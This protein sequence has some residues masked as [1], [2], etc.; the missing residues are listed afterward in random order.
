M[1]DQPNYS[2]RQRS[3]VVSEPQCQRGASVPHGAAGPLGRMAWRPLLLLPLLSVAVSGNTAPR[4][5]M[6]IVSVPE[7]LP[8]GASAFWL[9]AVDADGDQLYY[10]MSGQDAFY[11]KVDS[12]TGEVLLVAS[13]DREEKAKLSVIITVTDQINTEVSGKLAIIVEDRNDNPPI[14]QNQPYIT[15]LSETWPIGSSI[16]RVLAT[17]ADSGSAGRVRYEIVSVTP[18]DAKNHQLF[19]ILQNGTVVLNGSLNY[20]SQSTYY[21]LRIN[22]TDGV[23]CVEN[24]TYLSSVAYLSVNVVDEPDLAPQFLNEPYV[25]SVPENCPLGTPVLTVS[26]IDRD[27]GVNYALNYSLLN[28]SVPF[29]IHLA[30]GT[31]TVRSALDRERLPSEEVLLEVLVQEEKLDIYGQ[32]AQASA[33]V[34][35]QVTDVNDN[36]PQFYECELPA[37]DFTASPQSSFRGSLE[38]HSST[39]VPVGGLHIVAHDPDKGSNGAFELQLQGP[40]AASFSVSPSRLTGTGAVQVLVKDPSTVDYERTH[41][42]TVE[43]I[44]NDTGNPG[45]CCSIAIVTIQLL[46][47]NDHSPR[48]GQSMYWLPVLENSPAGTVISSNITATDPDSADFGRITY[49]LLPETILDIFAV[50]ASSGEVLVRNGS[51]LDRETRSVYYATLQAVDG[52][53]MT[54]STYL[55]ITLQDANDNAPVVS[56]SYNVFVNEGQENISVQIQAFDNDEPGTSNSH[57]RFQLEPGA[58]SAN[59]TIDPATGVLRSLGALDRE[60]LGRALQG[61]VVVTVRVHDLGVPQLSSLVNVTI[62]VEDVNDNAPVFLNEPYV[63]SVREGQAG[64]FVG[65]VEAEDA[66]QTEVHHRISFQLGSSSSSFLLR[67]VRLGPGHYQGNLSL[68]PDVAL[69]YDRL[70]PAHF[71]LTVRA[72]NTGTGDALNVVLTTVYVQVLDVNDEPPALVPASPQDVSVA[73]DAQPGLLTTLQASD[74]DTNHSLHFQELGLAC[75]KGA[76][77]AGHVC[78]DWFYLAPNG[79]VFLNS[80]QIDYEVCDLVTV[81]L[82]VEDTRTE[83]GNPYSNNATLRIL[84]SDVNDNSPEFLPISDTFVVV[85]EVSPVD[86]PVAVVKAR[87]ADTGSRG[88]ITF[89]ISRVVFLQDNG[90][91]HIL[92]SVF[93]V[94]T[95]AEGDLYVGSIQVA[96][97]LD[98]SLKGRYQVTVEA[99]DGGTQSLSSLAVLDIFTVDQSY[100]VRLVFSTSVNEVQD[101]SVK[102]KAAL[103]VATRATVYVAVI[104]SAADA[105]QS[106]S[107]RAQEKSVM[108]AYFVYS[109]GTALGV[110]ELSILVQSNQQALSE[111]IQLGLTIIGPGTVVEPSKEKELIGVIVG[112]A[113]GLMLLLLVMTL[114]LLATRRSYRRKLKAMK[115]LKMASTLT[116]NVAQQGPAIPGT[117]KYNA[118]GAN[119]VLNLTLDPPADLGFDEDSD[120]DDASLNSLDENM[121]EN[122]AEGSP[123]PPV[124]QLGRAGALAHLGSCEEPLTAALQAH[125]TNPASKPARPPGDP[126]RTFT[127]SNPCLDTTDL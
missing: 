24:C 69:D 34:T 110:N 11:F 79:S 41:V 66:D 125:R 111:L 65:S 72:E 58:F 38:E 25:G 53:G 104:Q 84:I 89:T 124:L 3:V 64:T 9:T 112:L 32:V 113:A 100:R 47:I 13:L 68:D 78:Q 19:C 103:T 123:G 20:N 36:T 26:A 7:D 109:N 70:S 88:A 1:I 83:E 30:T 119:P 117:N 39:R 42:M 71:N 23:G 44:A 105:P 18:D 43:I 121:V 59:F 56:G 48:F 90:P 50:N 122:P 127:F 21:Q 74:L 120:A 37:C 8:V 93:K 116:A 57:L 63:F 33:T 80:S 67:S 73:E 118:E 87:D 35:I 6:S 5:N 2:R 27:K 51:L 54:G 92:S 15:D 31:V 17:D 55:E 52:G 114:A 101:N 16:Y 98:G 96:S 40:D 126:N 99:Q 76:G 12:T 94:V 75:Y 95:A 10:G 85:P 22:A 81:T 106:R 49:K 14:F 77:S 28:A 4:F 97:N 60:A 46:D 86:L 107:S 45:N 115:A 102:I 91:N 29:A 108:E 62:T 82:R 61:K